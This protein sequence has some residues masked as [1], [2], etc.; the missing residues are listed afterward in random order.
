MYAMIFAADSAF[1]LEK[2]LKEILD[3]LVVFAHVYVTVIGLK[4]FYGQG[5]RN[6]VFGHCS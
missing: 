3:L 4:G 6:R 1:I 5:R 2:R